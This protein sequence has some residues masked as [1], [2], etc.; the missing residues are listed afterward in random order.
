[1]TIVTRPE[2]E[3]GQYTGYKLG[4]ENPEV[5]DEEVDA[6]IDELRKQNATVVDRKSVV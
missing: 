3:L 1:M 6:A 4:K 2:A 5:K